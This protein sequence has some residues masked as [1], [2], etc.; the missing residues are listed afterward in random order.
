MLDLLKEWNVPANKKVEKL[1]NSFLE[2]HGGV[3]KLNEELHISKPKEDDAGTTKH[4]SAIK[5]S[6]SKTST[7]STSEPKLK[8]Q[9]TLPETR[10]SK[11]DLQKKLVKKNEIGEP[12]DFKVLQNIVVEN[13]KFK[14][15]YHFV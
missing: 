11:R 2:T 14:V 9:S 5:R 1:I 4:V 3:D 8:R 12:Y 10:R 7:A 15:C 6:A 13:G